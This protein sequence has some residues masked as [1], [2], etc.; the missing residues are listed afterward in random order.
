LYGSLSG[1]VSRAG[2]NL[3]SSEK[4]YLGGSSGVRAYPS[5]EAGGGKGVMGNIELRWQPDARLMLAGFYDIGHV[6]MYPAKN[7]QDVTALNQYSLKG[8][9]FSAAWQFDN[10]AALKVIWARRI[11]DNPN[12]NIETGKDL[13][14]SL[15]RTRLWTSFNLPF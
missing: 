3:D 12:A 5:S 9:G 10:G 2:K 8:A 4:F 13:D 11:G 14:G 7:L 1:Q 6:V 15:V